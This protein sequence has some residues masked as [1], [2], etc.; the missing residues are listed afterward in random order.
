MLLLRQI[1]I[2]LAAFGILAAQDVPPVPPAADFAV[3]P[4]TVVP[5]S[6]INSISTKHSVA[7]DRVYLETAFPILSGGR[8][9]I[10]VGSYVEGTVTEIKKPGRVKGRGELYVRFDSLTLPNGVTRDFRGRMGGMDGT[11][12]GSVDR[13]EGKVTAEGNRGGDLKTIGEAA[14]TGASVG[15]IVGS[16]AGRP[17]TGVALGAAAGAAAGLIGVLVSRGPDAI[18]ARGT[19]VE[20]VLDRQISFNEAELNFGNYQPPRVS[21]PGPGAPGAPDPNLPPV[22]RRIPK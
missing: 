8:I 2:S 7:G 19:T 10:P 15:G 3:K 12:P 16:V 18:L 1:A 21:G 9:V 11:A 13:T 20:M 5:L 4:G 6:L 17:G 22:M 14:G